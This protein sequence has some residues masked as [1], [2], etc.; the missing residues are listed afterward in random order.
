[1]SKRFVE[2][3]HNILSSLKKYEGEVGNLE[4]ETIWIKGKDSFVAKFLSINKLLD[5]SVQNLSNILYS[6]VQLVLNEMMTNRVVIGRVH[7]S[8]NYRE[9]EN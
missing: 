2:F 4:T 1:M 3:E 5:F 9:N 7:S 6:W 8:S